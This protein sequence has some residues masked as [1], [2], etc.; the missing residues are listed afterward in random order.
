MSVEEIAKLLNTEDS[1]LLTL[2]GEYFYSPT[3]SQGYS[4]CDSNDGE[5]ECDGLLLTTP[6]QLHITSQQNLSQHLEQQEEDY[7]IDSLITP[8]TSNTIVVKPEDLDLDEG[9]ENLR[10]REEIE[11]IYSSGCCATHRLRRII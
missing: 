10:E 2:L 1:T 7:D 8:G 6:K 5:D 4:D 3:Q 11:A 9:A